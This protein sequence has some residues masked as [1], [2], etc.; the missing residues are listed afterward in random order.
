[1]EYASA[2]VPKVHF[3]ACEGVE[4]DLLLDDCP[5][6]ETFG[7]QDLAIMEVARRHFQIHREEYE[8]TKSS[9]LEKRVLIH[10][11]Q[12]LTQRIIDKLQKRDPKDRE[13][14]HF[15]WRIAK[16]GDLNT[17]YN[18]LDRAQMQLLEHHPKLWEYDKKISW[19][20]IRVAAVKIIQK[21]KIP[22]PF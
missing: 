6:G 4:F 5:I 22:S 13:F 20:R 16:T 2:L 9:S 15:I 12:Q 3:P 11:A 7:N 18:D 1:M 8:V 21:H 14:K 17:V 10:I 19:M